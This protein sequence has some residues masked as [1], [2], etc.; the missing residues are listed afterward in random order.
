MF[1]LLLQHTSNSSDFCCNT[2]AIFRTFVKR[3]DLSGKTWVVL[4]TF[5][6]TIKQFFGLLLQHFSIYINFCVL[7]HNNQCSGFCFFGLEFVDCLFRLL[8]GDCLFGLLLGDCLFG[9]LLGDCLF[10]LRLG[11]CL[12][13]LML[14]DSKMSCSKLSK[15]SRWWSEWKDLW[16]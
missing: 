16:W 8:L 15:S 11:D 3:L 14:G 9:F 13:G 10:G 12:F 1:G 4:Q 5:V 7:I 6:A 2:R